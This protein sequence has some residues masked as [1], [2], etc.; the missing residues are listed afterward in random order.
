MT[1]PEPI[2]HQAEIVLNAIRTRRT[3]RDFTAEPVSVADVRRILEAA[4]WASSGG[5]RRIQKYVV[6]RDP[7]KIRLVDIVAPGFRGS[8]TTLIVICTDT[9]K[10][11]E[12][13]VQLNK[14]TTT[15]IDTGTAAMNMQIAAHAL[16][17]GS[18]PVTSFSRSGVREALD[19]PLTLVPEL[20]LQLGHP[21]QDGPNRR[22]RRPQLKLTV[23]ELT[24]W[25]CFGGRIPGS[26]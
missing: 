11:A 4:Q 23:E 14:H 26:D 12:E 8:P 3:V 22:A 21:A 18:T 16:G 25:E 6:V 7:A 19:L 9:V 24:H 1:N 20:I 15:W 10:A 13:Q 17:L 5:N 2:G